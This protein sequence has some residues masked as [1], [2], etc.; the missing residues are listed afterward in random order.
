MFL[1]GM[2]LGVAGALLV[3]MFL[4]PYMPTFLRVEEEEVTGVVA[5]KRGDTDRLLL[6]VR[7][8]RGAVLATF[9]RRVPEIDL[10][11]SRGDTVVLGLGAYEPFVENPDLRG[12]RKAEEA[13]VGPRG[14]EAA[15]ESEA[16]EPSPGDTQAP[17]AA[18]TA[19]P[20]QADTAGPPASDTVR[21]PR[22]TAVG[23]ATS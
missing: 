23:G 21:A 7:T 17:P 16:T 9:T 22:D 8:Q 14:A 5:D 1:F 4:G 13:A 15:G 20:P 11:V 10:L 6:T 12:V 2:V 3:P 18:D 19:R